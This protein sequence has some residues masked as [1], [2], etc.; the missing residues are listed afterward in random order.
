[1]WHHGL[2]PRKRAAPKIPTP[3]LPD[4]TGI[5]APVV[6][7]V[8]DTLQ[9]AGAFHVSATKQA[10]AGWFPIHS[11]MGVM[12]LE[13]HARKLQRRWARDRRILARIRRERRTIVAE[14]VGFFDLFVPV[15]LVGESFV[16]AV[17]GPFARERATSSEVRRRFTAITGRLARAG[18]PAFLDYVGRTL[19]TLTLEG[20]A[21]D[22]FRRFMECF[23]ALARGE[24]NTQALTREVEDLRWKVL[25]TRSV[26]DMWKTTHDLVGER[27]RGLDPGSRHELSLVGLEQF[28][29]HVLVGLVRDV[30][31][32]RDPIDSI[33]ARDGFQRA[34]VVLAK[35]H[36]RV[37]CG[38]HGGYGVVFLVDDPGAGAKQRARCVA[39][40]ERIEKLARRF[41]LE[42]H[43]GLA[44]SDKP[45]LLPAQYRRALAAAEQAL[46]H[47]QRL[48]H[49]DRTP[50]T[51]SGSLGAIRRELGRAVVEAPA[52]LERRFESFIE[53]ARI[54][55]GFQLEP[56]GVHLEVAFEQIMSV[57][58][59]LHILDSSALGELALPVQNG[60]RSAE[61][62]LGL[63]D[64]YRRGVAS[65]ARVLERPGAGRREL[66]LQRAIEYARD[67]LSEPL[68]LTRVA[69]V[70]GRAPRQ[71]TELFRTG[72]GMTFHQ[73]VLRL[74]LERAQSMLRSTSLSAE[75][76]APLVGFGTREQFH[77]AF[78]RAFR[79]TPQEYRA[80]QH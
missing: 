21:Y 56:A 33:V 25:A 7:S 23:A 29:E 35:K 52:I 45:S 4:K 38:K 5:V 19:A 59:S 63:E 30:V 34:S 57:L 9:V 75:R 51:I 13:S 44:L 43:A 22:H 17:V 54:H 26:E 58:E 40:S 14:Y 60:A 20:D 36:G 71:F 72:Q 46:A 70:A 62:L 76:I 12:A 16:T 69:R 24:K 73:Y 78:K 66:G 28:P 27:A 18:D 32:D 64:V 50:P 67:H 8:L 53:A 31:K 6:A 80:R 47:H 65:V 42:L 2:V 77:R 49:A 1:L 48:C 61:T 15:G 79:L 74:R 10:E 11:E 55:S 39:F 41:E 68:T 3:R 37:M